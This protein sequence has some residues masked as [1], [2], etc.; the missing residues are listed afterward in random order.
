MSFGRRIPR[1]LFA[2]NAIKMSSQPDLLSAIRILGLLGSSSFAKIC[3]N[4]DLADDSGIGERNDS[5]H[6]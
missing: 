4:K 6:E 2:S 3:E 1:G 5:N